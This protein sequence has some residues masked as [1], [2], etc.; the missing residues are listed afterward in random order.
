MDVGRVYDGTLFACPVP[1]RNFTTRWYGLIF[2]VLQYAVSFQKMGEWV[3][4]CQLPSWVEEVEP[5][6]RNTLMPLRLLMSMANVRNSSMPSK[7]TAGR[8]LTALASSDG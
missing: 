8:P 6:T 1:K 4:P 3:A 7:A 2:T 5:L